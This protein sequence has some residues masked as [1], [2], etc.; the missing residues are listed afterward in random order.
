MPDL[1]TPDRLAE[2][3]TIKDAYGDSTNLD[4]APGHIALEDLLTERESLL[5]AARPV[6][7]DRYHPVRCP[8]SSVQIEALIY[9]ANGYSTGHHAELH[10]ENPHTIKSRRRKALLTLQAA[11]CTQAVGI[12]MAHGWITADD[13][14]LPR[15]W[16]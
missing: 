2:I 13:I 14:T 4:L 8:I 7:A 16:S 6:H 5:V 11:N 10:D 3:I 15:T 12:C 1:L 9:A